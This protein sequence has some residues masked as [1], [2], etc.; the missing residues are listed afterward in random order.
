M[1]THGIEIPPL[2]KFDRLSSMHADDVAN[3][4]SSYGRKCARAAIDADRKLHPEVGKNAKKRFESAMKGCKE[5][6]PIE[7][8]R[9]YCSLAMSG[10]DWLDA[11]PFFDALVA[12]RKRRG[13][14]V[15]Y[16][17]GGF[18]RIYNGPGD[19]YNVGTIILCDD[20]PEAALSAG[21]NLYAAPQPAEPVHETARTAGNGAESGMNTGPQSGAHSAS[22]YS[23]CGCNSDDCRVNGCLSKRQAQS[24]MATSGGGMPT[25]PVK[26]PSDDVLDAALSNLEHDNYEQ[27]YSGYKNRQ[28]DI[29][30]IR[31]LLARYGKTQPAEPGSYVHTAPDDCETLHWRG[32]ILSLN[33]LATISAEPVKVPSDD[34]TD[35]AR[36]RKARTLPRSWWRDAFNRVSTP[37]ELEA[38]IDTHGERRLP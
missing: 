15:A 17:S 23:V 27:S 9:F 24:A 8:L 34:A 35:A 30:L 14:P 16:V 18:R 7:R 11:E 28:A 32:Q 33:E 25:E 13:E 20:S 36:W 6:D 29:A 37:E 10:Q 5:T 19:W 12:D 21:T 3:L 31:A 2:P 38:L 1:N 22:S 4:L 26:V